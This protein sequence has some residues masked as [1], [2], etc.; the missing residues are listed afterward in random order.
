M[1]ECSTFGWYQSQFTFQFLEK[2][3]VDKGY[4]IAGS[5]PG[6]SGVFFSGSATCVEKASDYAYSE[7]NRVRNKAARLIR[8]TMMP[9]IIDIVKKTLRLV[10][11]NLLQLEDGKV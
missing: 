10:S 4:I 11:V 2:A 5:Y 8:L 3:I 9:E 6:Y 1:V 7:N